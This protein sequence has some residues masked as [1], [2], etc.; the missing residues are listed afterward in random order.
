MV[1]LGIGPRARDAVERRTRSAFVKRAAVAA[2]VLAIPWLA[3]IPLAVYRHS[4][5]MRFGISVQAWPSWSIDLL[6]AAAI[7]AIPTIL[8]LIGV[9]AAA[10]RSPRRWWIYAW[11]LGV[12]VMIAATYVAPLIVDPLFYNFKPLEKSNPDLVRALQQVA[13]RA[14][15]NIPADRIF[16]MDASRNTRAVNAYMTGFGHSRRIVIWDTTLKV[17][18][19]PQIQ[20]VFGHELGHYALGHIPRSLAIAA[21][22]LL[23]ALWILYA[24]LRR[25][26][27]TGVRDTSDPAI[28]P[29]AFT[30]V[31]ILGFFSEPLANTYSRWQEHQADI[32]ELEVMHGLVPDAGRNSAD[33]DQIM[34]QIDLDDPQPNPFIRFWIYD[35]P[36]TN[37]RMLFA[38]RYD[39]WAHGE[40]PEFVG[41]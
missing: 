20:T 22:G 2:V 33:V 29:V 14:G 27:P 10:R 28:L 26:H 13:A 41:K 3:D 36:P 8:F 5:S 32:Y 11:L 15:Y 30:V 35:H 34:A 7:T 31:L 23:L 17:L 12:F 39:P 25:V 21:T 16:E 24:F 37:E 9:L 4:L 1:L 40:S 38:Q 18:D 19:T 6:K